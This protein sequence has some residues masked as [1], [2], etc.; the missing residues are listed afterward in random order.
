MCSLNFR[1][2][3]TSNV[4]Y[5]YPSIA[6]LEAKVICPSMCL[7]GVRV[8]CNIS[9]SLSV[10]FI[11]QLIIVISHISSLDKASSII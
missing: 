6:S 11:S 8:V 7:L 2:I 5:I 3:A 1:F 10:L 4:T 9:S